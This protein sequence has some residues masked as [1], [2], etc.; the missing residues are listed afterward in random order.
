MSLFTLTAPRVVRG[1]SVVA[2][3]DR[4][5]LFWEPDLVPLVRESPDAVVHAQQYERLRL[6][7][8][9]IS[10]AALVI[11]G[12][13]IA[14]DAGGDLLSREGRWA[15]LG[16]YVALGIA[17]GVITRRQYRA[18]QAALDAYNADLQDRSFP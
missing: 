14:D 1:D 9:L 13:L 16:G 15:A 5:G 4:L 12:S 8:A 2:G 7:S 10:G 11:V 18:R 17:G 3:G 6:P